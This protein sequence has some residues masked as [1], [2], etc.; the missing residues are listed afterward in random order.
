MIKLRDRLVGYIVARRQR[1]DEQHVFDGVADLDVARPRRRGSGRSGPATSKNPDRRSAKPTTSSSN[2]VN[3]DGTSDHRT[4]REPSHRHRSTTR[5]RGGGSRSAWPTRWCGCATICGGE[6]AFPLLD[7]LR[8]ECRRRTRPNGLRHPAARTSARASTSTCR[9]HCRSSHCP[10]VAALALQVPIAQCADRTKRIPLVV[11]GAL[12]L[13]L[14]SGLTGLAT[15]LIILTIVRSG[16]SLGKAFIDPTHNSL[17]ADYYPVETRSPGVQLPPGG[18]RRRRDHRA[19]HRRLPRLLVRLASAV[20]RLRHPDRDLRAARPEAARARSAADGN[21]TR[22]VP[23]RRSS[24][25]RRR[26]R[27]SPRAGARSTRSVRFIES[28]GA[29]PFLAPAFIG[30][31]VARLRCSTSRSSASATVVEAS[32]PPSP[33]RSRSSA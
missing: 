23:A 15:G 18:Q 22:P 6:A 11:A 17:I 24:T 25:P 7:A 32:P 30:F 27:R 8:A 20:P 19:D 21:V 2:G 29:F 10:A 26:R 31:I 12:L 5:R 1:H 4:R 3:R 14:F 9:R 28:G 16:S 13:A 33:S